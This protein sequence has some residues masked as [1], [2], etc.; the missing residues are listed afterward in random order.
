MV[1]STHS[2]SELGTSSDLFGIQV[3]TAQIIMIMMSHQSN[4][5]LLLTPFELPGS[6]SANTN[7]NAKDATARARIAAA[8][9]A[10]E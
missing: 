8:A 5:M 3:G 1:L 9:A 2:E 6:M 4:A 10:E 7:K